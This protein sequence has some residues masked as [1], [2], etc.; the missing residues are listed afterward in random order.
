MLL[1]QTFQLAASMSRHA[2]A[3][4][5]ELTSR[6][7]LEE[8]MDHLLAWLEREEICFNEMG[9]DSVD[10]DLAFNPKY[11][12]NKFV[13]NGIWTENVSVDSVDRDLASWYRSS[14][15]CSKEERRS[16]P[17]GAR[18]L[19]VGKSIGWHSV[20]KEGGKMKEVG[21]QA[22]EGEGRS[23]GWWRKEVGKRESRGASGS[24]RKSPG[25][26]RDWGRDG[27]ETRID[28]EVERKGQRARTTN[29][30]PFYLGLT[31]KTSKSHR[32]NE[33]EQ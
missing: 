13:K 17:F 14:V 5:H 21:K 29:W 32:A 3:A 18:R 23:R 10:R 30:V 8:N 2:S 22:W 24:A 27:R 31:S 19:D 11:Y 20:E 16:S 4:R 12:L 9:V 7:K 26:E 1:I 33:R 25:A 15:D 28:L 6:F